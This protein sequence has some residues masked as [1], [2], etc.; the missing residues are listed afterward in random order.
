[1]DLG[2]SNVPAGR[3][4]TIPLPHQVYASPRCI[5]IV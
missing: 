3:R 2:P 4:A 1:M 5:I